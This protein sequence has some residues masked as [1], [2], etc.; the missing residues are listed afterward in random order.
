MKNT[1][2]F[3]SLLLAI[4]ALSFSAQSNLL[5]YI[6]TNEFAV[7]KFD[8]A[9]LKSKSKALNQL[10]ISDS[11]SNQFSRLL[12]EYKQVLIDENTS[13]SDSE[14]ED[15]KDQL[16]GG[17]LE[18]PEKDENEAV[19]ELIEEYDYNSYDNYYKVTPKLKLEKLFVALMNR[20]SDYGVNNNANYY[21]IVGMNDSINH[22]ALLF[23]K[24]DE[25][26]FGSF[27]NSIIPESQKKDLVI[28]KNGYEY[29]SDEDIMIAWNKEVVAFINYTIPYR[30]RYSDHEE[31]T[32]EEYYESYEERLA[33]KAKKKEEEK[34]L[35]LESVLND[36]FN[37]KP[38]HSLKFSANYTKSLSEKGDISYFMNALGSNADLYFKA[39]GGRS[40]KR[41]NEF[42]SM[43]KDNFGYGSL[44]F[45]DNDISLKSLQHVGSKYIKQMKV[46]N[47]K[48]FN[49][50]MFKYIG[51]DHLLGIAGFS[52]K[53]E[54]AYE[55]YR[56]MYVSILG[57]ISEDESWIGTAADIGFTFFDEE[58]L[59]DLVQGDFVFAVTD[60]KEFEVEYTSYDYD[61]DYNRVEK[62]KTK[63]ETLPEFVSLATIGNKELRDKIIKLMTQTDVI[64][65][66]DH[67]FEL[68]E[69]KSR[70]SD[71]AAKPLNVFYM[72]KDDLLVITNNEELLKNNEGNGLSKSEQLKGEAYSLMKSNNMFA[73]W[74]PKTTYEKVPKE[75]TD[76]VKP[77]K[78]I[79]D[80]YQSFQFS[81]VKNKGNIFT[82]TAKIS[83]IDNSK[84]S[85]MLS[86]DLI[87][88]MMK[89][90]AGVN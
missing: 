74:T 63:K 30:Y 31:S 50:S 48:K 32:D 57:N 82:S 76:Q 43:F 15:I 33:A 51:G 29:Y 18:S 8:G 2:T 69:P 19:E 40:S 67:Y 58:E 53:P 20:G 47:K 38:E 73:Y 24:S 6:P 45:N 86:L 52:V 14:I 17:T 36:L 1:S 10:A 85:L 66:K 35:K 77:F 54:P 87:N 13:V 46:M 71:R 7:V 89:V 68:Q 49:K 80:T 81:G 4:S 12:K 61:D 64:V 3:L 70:Y 5:E 27:I 56:D 11:I 23:N 42:M 34:R 88:E 44:N 79:A 28:L 65:K 16:K 83:L 26:K 21:F 62:I 60:I 41:S 25:A 39:F 59:F 22:N 55:M 78:S 37:S 9:T 72:I 90:V 84:G 75:F